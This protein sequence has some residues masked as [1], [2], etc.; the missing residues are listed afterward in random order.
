MAVP[1]TLWKKWL[2]NCELTPD[3]DAIVHWIAGEE[4]IRWTFTSLI[5]AAKRFSQFIYN[6]GIKPGNVCAIIIRHNPYLYPLYMGISR[7]GAL[8]AILAYPNPRL[9]PEKFR[10]GLEGMAQRSGLDYILTERELEPIIRPLIE[11]PGSTIKAIYLPLEWNLNDANDLALDSI[12]EEAASA[13]KE[14][15]PFL[16]QHSSG[17]TGLQKPIAV[18]HKALLEHVINC[19]D[20]LHTS[21]DDI[22]VSWLPL[23]HDMGLIGA[24]HIPLAT[25]M[26]SIHISPFEWILAP[27]LLLEVITKEKATFSYIPNFAYNFLAE[28]IPEDELENIDLSSL[29]LLINGAEPIR[30][31]SH[32]KFVR[33][34]K[35]YNFNPL[36]L[37]S[38]Y[39]MA[40]LTLTLTYTE[41]GKPLTELALDRNKLSEGR[42]KFAG[43]DSVV[44]VCVSCGKL[45]NGADA[46]IV[47]VNRRELPESFVGEIAVKSVSMFEGYRNYPEKTLEVF[48][49]GWY[50]TGDYGFKYNDEFFIIGRKKDL[51]IVA[52]KNL[53]PEDIEETVNQVEGVIP[54]RV[55][56]FG[57]EDP[58][59]GTEKVSVVAE[60]RVETESE[61]NKLRVDILKA[62]MSIDVNINKVYLAPPRWLIKSSSGKPSRKA[63]KE[64][65]T[66]KEDPQIWSR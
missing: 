14:T 26:T 60:T 10:Q 38:V 45:I 61:R 17:T 54:G 58:E 53:Y 7:T 23:Y 8:P 19:N 9:H 15:E 42:V 25:G 39:G 1:K 51:I 49:D 55:I 48:E 6:V 44:R 47:D 66:L 52:G 31:D 32:E 27:I 18:T 30:H 12:I 37:A 13:V 20:A 62:G 56:A 34:F 28:K 40:E 64:R 65:L 3:K 4:P 50:Y 59:L 22:A 2:Q 46:H 63:N 24:F 35:K 43:R 41:P 5:D 11:K 36:A 16:V 29:K 57:E 21:R 33:R